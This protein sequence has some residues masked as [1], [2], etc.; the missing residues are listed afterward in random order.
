MKFTA[1][2]SAALLAL[3]LG[4]GARAEQ[5]SDAEANFQLTVPAGWQTLKAK[6]E[7]VKLALAK[8]VD[9][10]SHGVCVVATQ[11]HL[12]TKQL[13]QAEVDAKIGPLIDE[14]F[15]Q[16]ALTMTPGLDGA[17][18]KSSSTEVKNGRNVYTVVM[19]IKLKA[20]D[21]KDV[22]GTAKE[23]MLIVPGQFYFVTCLTADT[24]YAAFEDDFEIVFDSFRP[25]TDTPVAANDASGVS[26][27]TLYSAAQFGGV[28]RVVTQD[29]ADLTRYGWRS[30]TGSVSVAGAAP[31]E[32]CSGTNYSGSCQIVSGALASNA[33]RG[34]GVLSARRVQAASAPATLARSLQSD[35][36]RALAETIQRAR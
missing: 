27:L 12:E 20:K 29:T 22:D 32:V 2:L 8:S 35:V 21:G 6:N 9:N 13:T 14:K 26:A 19:A 17:T 11:V 1:I 30:G 4:S 24:T 15:W 3:A 5:Y 34:A 7:F 25:L 10:E 23:I 36:A 33:G 16:F 28:S 31:W 18:L